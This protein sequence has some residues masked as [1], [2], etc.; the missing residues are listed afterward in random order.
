MGSS[1]FSKGTEIL[2]QYKLCACL[3]KSK[4]KCDLDR[5]HCERTND[6]VSVITKANFVT[7]T[8]EVKTNCYITSV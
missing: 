2:W 4:A 3:N 1:R 8:G 6:G 7:V 5:V